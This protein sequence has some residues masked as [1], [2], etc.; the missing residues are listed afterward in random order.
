MNR[1]RKP[2]LIG[3]S[4][5]DT[6]EF[7]ENDTVGYERKIRSLLDTN[8]LLAR[9]NQFLS[10]QADVLRKEHDALGHM[11]RSRIALSNVK[12]MELK[13]ALEGMRLVVQEKEN[14]VESLER[15]YEELL[16]KMKSLEKPKKNGTSIKPR[17]I[18]NRKSYEIRRLSKQFSEEPPEEEKSQEPH[19][20]Q[21][22]TPDGMTEAY[23]P[24]LSPVL[25]RLETLAHNHGTSFKGL[26][27]TSFS[28]MHED[29]TE[30]PET[31]QFCGLDDAISC[32]GDCHTPHARNED[33][34]VMFREEGHDIEFVSRCVCWFYR[35]CVS[36]GVCSMVCSLLPPCYVFLRIHPSTYCVGSKPH[37]RLQ[38]LPSVRLQEEE[39]S[40]TMHCRA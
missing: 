40:S 4:R 26:C 20:S 8:R 13:S 14:A 21:S 6:S 3:V 37:F 28:T 12:E 16:A 15:K 34:K 22:P 35:L 30:A 24:W 19:E 27:R 31:L 18:S 1:S 25:M 39:I 5:Q 33:Q 10:Q 7:K 23:H 9:E 11:M 36:C 2:K 38:H 32:T 29:L 17:R